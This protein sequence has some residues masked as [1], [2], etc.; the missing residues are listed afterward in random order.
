MEYFQFWMDFMQHKLI[1]SWREDDSFLWGQKVFF[2]LDFWLC[3]HCLLL[4]F[5]Y[6]KYPKI[7]TNGMKNVQR[8]LKEEPRRATPRP[9]AT[10]DAGVDCCSRCSSI[11][12]R[13]YFGTLVLT[14][15]WNF[16]LVGVVRH[17]RSPSA[18]IAS[19]KLLLTDWIGSKKSDLSAFH[20]QLTHPKLLFSLLL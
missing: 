1:P 18:T 3:P 16:L 7:W 2:S 17:K 14:G 9:T 8:K 11:T 6:P 15:F 5:W 4:F 12:G 13:L 20:T 10:E 19:I